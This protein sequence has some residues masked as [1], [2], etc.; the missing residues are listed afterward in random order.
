MGLVGYNMINFPIGVI[1]GTIILI[2]SL[3]DIYLI[4]HSKCDVFKLITLIVYSY[5]T[6]YGVYF[7]A[8]GIFYVFDSHILGEFTSGEIKGVVVIGSLSGILLIYYTTTK[9]IEFLTQK[10]KNGSE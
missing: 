4:K 10:G 9:F 5:I 1:F 6:G 7:L 3:M 8:K 2:L